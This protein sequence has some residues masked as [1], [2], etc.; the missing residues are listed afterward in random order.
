MG[1]ELRGNLFGG[2]KLL[3][4][5]AVWVEI[6]DEGAMP[7]GGLLPMSLLEIAIHYSGSDL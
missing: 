7:K 2:I 4:A 3:G 6:S 1:N 5:R